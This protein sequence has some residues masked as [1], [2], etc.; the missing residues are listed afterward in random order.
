VEQLPTQADGH[1]GLHPVAGDSAT[2]ARAPGLVQV[3]VFAELIRPESREALRQISAIAQRLG[4]SLEVRVVPIGL[5]DDSH[6]HDSG[7]KPDSKEVL[8]ST[9]A[10]CAEKHAPSEFL[11]VLV[12]QDGEPS[13]WER[14]ARAA[15]LTDGAV[16]AIGRCR[17]GNEGSRLIGETYERS[18]AGRRGAGAGFQIS[19]SRSSGERFYLSEVE[20]DEFL[21]RRI[22]W[23][24]LD[25]RPPVCEKIPD[26]TRV[27]IL[28]D[29]RCKDCRTGDF[30]QEIRGL[31]GDP[32]VTR[33]DYGEPA[34]QELYRSL[35]EARELPL[36]LFDDSF[37]GDRFEP[38]SYSGKRARLAPSMEPFGR[39]RSL[40]IGASWNP[41]CADPES[42]ESEKCQASRNCRRE[43]Q[44]RLEVFVR[45]FSPAGVSALNAVAPLV[46][47]FGDELEIVPRFIFS[48]SPTGVRVGGDVIDTEE[49]ARRLCV[50]KHYK[51]E[52]RW[53]DYVLCQN[54]NLGNGGFDWKSCTDARKPPC[55]NEKD[56]RLTGAGGNGLSRRTCEAARK[57]GHAV[58]EKCLRSDEVEVLRKQNDDAVTAQAVLAPVWVVNNLYKVDFD[59]SALSVESMK[60]MVCEHNGRL[61]GCQ[62][63]R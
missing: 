36:V 20:V 53:L 50:F 31:L 28:D 5:A 49:N 3:T 46:E 63:A 51:K 33:V 26:R 59:M 42:C 43:Q 10:V 37:D 47:L 16:E 17:E 27:L 40:S 15:H 54:A 22:C 2:K 21:F 35:P 61:R 13:D 45:S 52:T 62:L 9:L 38:S 48:G 55:P 57:V 6:G 56:G 39:Y 32:I 18:A 41:V 29:K 14:C 7:R 19:L 4:P 23:A 1:E 34:G 11:S 58:V 8:I 30:E 60:R 24:Y 12:C 44:G 25:S